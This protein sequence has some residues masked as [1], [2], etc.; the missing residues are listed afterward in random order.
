MYSLSLCLSVYLSIFPSISAH[1]FSL[2][3]AFSLTHSL[4]H[5]ASFCHCSIFC[6]SINLFQCLLGQKKKKKK[7]ETG[8]NLWAC[9]MMDLT[10]RQIAGEAQN[11]CRVLL[12]DVGGWGEE[13]IQA[14][15]SFHL[16]YSNSD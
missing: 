14:W 11:G 7:Q 5:S 4:T 6:L 12:G 13:R 2:S 9:E 10:R 15:M 8:G 16:S 1:V 3:P